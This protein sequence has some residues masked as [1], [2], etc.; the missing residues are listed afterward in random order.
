MVWTDDVVATPFSTRIIPL[1]I[2]LTSSESRSWEQLAEI[3]LAREALCFA[4]TFLLANPGEKLSRSGTF[5]DKTFP[6]VVCSS[7]KGSQGSPKRRVRKLNRGRFAFDPMGTG[8]SFDVQL[9]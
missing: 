4:G 9:S 1:T 2:R 5:F 3:Y 6:Q 7:I 8:S